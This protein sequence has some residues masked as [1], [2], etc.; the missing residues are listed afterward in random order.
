MP[1]SP[2]FAADNKHNQDIYIDSSV[3]I[4]VNVYSSSKLKCFNI[5]EVDSTSVI[6]TEVETH[7]VLIKESVHGAIV[8]L[9][10]TEIIF[11]LKELNSG[12]SRL[13]N[14][15]VCNNFGMS[16]FV[17]HLKLYSGMFKRLYFVPF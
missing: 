16:S 7:P 17:V 1:G 8:T 6:S 9:N 4:K 11:T 13:F 14:I 15:T 3:K 10:G 5:T 12:G 2:V